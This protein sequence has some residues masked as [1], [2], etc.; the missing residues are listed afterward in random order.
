MKG[1][2]NDES[3]GTIEMK[4][5]GFLGEVMFGDLMGL[6]RTNTNGFDH[7]VD[8]ELNGVRIDL[9]TMARDYYWQEWYTQ[10][11]IKSQVTSPNYKNDVYLFANYHKKDSALEVIGW[12][13]KHKVKDLPMIE[14]GEMVKKGRKEFECRATMYQIKEP[15]MT[16]FR[17]P[18]I[19]EMDL[20]GLKVD[21]GTK[22]V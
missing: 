5:V 11:L 18:G 20:G 1:E 14:K 13:P 6:E 3:D 15:D 17:N 10:N 16:P 19:F 22:I 12:L 9:K 4:Y 2:R 21:S 8:F 7:G